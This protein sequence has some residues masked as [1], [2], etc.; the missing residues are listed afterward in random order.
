M[1]DFFRLKVGETVGEFKERCF[2][3]KSTHPEVSW[4]EFADGINTAL[5]ANRDESTYRK[6]CKRY[7]KE[8]N[9]TVSTP[10]DSMTD[11]FITI[12]GDNADNIN[13]QLEDLIRELKVER[14]KISDESSQ[15]RA[16]LRKMAREETIREIAHSFA[17]EM[18][19]KKI[20]DAYTTRINTTKML[21]EGILMISDWHFGMDFSNYF[22]TYNPGVCIDRLNQL[23]DEVIEIGQMYGIKKLHVV[24]LSDLIAGR[25][26]L[27]IRLESRV[28][29]IT[30]VMKVSEILAEFLTD[31]SKCFEI[32]YRDVVDNHS[33]LEPNKKDSLELETL[34]R[35]IPW[36]LTERLNNNKRIHIY[37]NEFS[38]DIISFKVFDFNVVGVHG[39]KDKPVRV[40]EN[41][42]NMTRRQNDLVLTAHLHHFSADEEHECIRVSNGSL[43]GVDTFANDLRLVSG[44]SQ[45]MI[46]CSQDNVTEAICKINLV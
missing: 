21:R 10:N 41:M 4:K 9:L 36:Y 3:M 31:L 15:N 39:H 30:Q 42:R 6:Q 24:N 8:N 44:A 22:N 46:I 14:I 40:I 17:Q 45:T 34:V 11:E 37:F 1:N 25:I 5:H 23:K 13:T 7:W 33:R 26:H 32:E 16:Y 12:S 43:M 27:T 19:S 28:D 20:L 2:R 38:D 18:S 35:I 29:V